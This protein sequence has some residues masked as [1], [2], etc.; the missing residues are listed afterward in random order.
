MRGNICMKKYDYT[1][2]LGWSHSRYRTFDECRRKYYYHYYGKNF[3]PQISEQVVQLK[4]LVSRPLLNGSIVHDLIEKALNH[5]K[6]NFEFVE[7]DFLEFAEKFIETACNNAASFEKYYENAELDIVSIETSVFEALGNFLK[8][9]RFELLLGST[10]ETRALWVIEPPGFGETRFQGKKVY[11]KVDFLVVEDGQYLVFD[12]KTGKKDPIQHAEQIK[13]YAL[14]VMDHYEAAVGSVNMNISY[15][16]GGYEEISV[17]VNPFDLSQLAGKIE[18][19]T[20]YM[21]DMCSDIQGNI[22]KP[23]DEFPLIA[24]PNRCKYCNFKLLC[25]RV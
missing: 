5:L 3:Q 1:D 8:S 18:S 19:Q 9:S 13:G 24:N 11:F 6:F 15:V 25:D 23:I 22:P 10:P 12:W 14:W 4:R 20:N 21:Y 17:D 2:I 16:T 7:A